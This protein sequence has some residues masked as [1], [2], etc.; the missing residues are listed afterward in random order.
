[1]KEEVN[2]NLQLNHENLEKHEISKYLDNYYNHLEKNFNT[3]R[4][5][6]E[7]ICLF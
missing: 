5:C 4:Y 6:A 2:S 1:M 7:I 3:R